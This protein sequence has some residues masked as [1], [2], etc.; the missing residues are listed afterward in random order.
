MG[1]RI[2]M[3]S[4]KPNP[5]YLLDTRLP[6]DITGVRSWFGLIQQVAYAFSDTEVMLP[7]RTLLKP[8]SEF[9]WTQELQDNF[10]KSKNKIVKAV[11]NGVKIYDPNK[12]TALCADWSKTGMGFMLVQ[13]NCMCETVKRTC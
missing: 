7:F 2:T 11:E 6:K 5:E 8:T 10:D 1:F 3:D 12:V 9:L 4:I 13:K